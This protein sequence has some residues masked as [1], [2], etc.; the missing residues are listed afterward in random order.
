MV[1]GDIVLCIH[2][3]PGGCWAGL[4]GLLEM[5]NA[6]LADRALWFRCSIVSEGACL[7]QGFLMPWGT[8]SGAAGDEVVWQCDDYDAAG[9]DAEDDQLAG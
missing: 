1:S 7:Y 2:C 6:R 5:Q 3:G 9:G 8:S 4:A